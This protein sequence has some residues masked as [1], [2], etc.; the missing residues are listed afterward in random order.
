MFEENL[1]AFMVDFASPVIWQSERKATLAHFDAPDSDVIGG[2]VTSR[3]YSIEFPA[4]AFP[5]FT[6]G[7][8]VLIGIGPGWSLDP[9][10]TRLVYNGPDELPDSGLFRVKGMMSLDDGVFTSAQLERLSS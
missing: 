6:I 3:A 9:F 5:G 2:L 1:D 4:K 10:G 8:I 7:E